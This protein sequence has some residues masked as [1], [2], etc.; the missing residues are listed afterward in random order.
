MARAVPILGYPSRAACVKAL[1]AEGLTA[2]AI[3]ARMTRESGQ[4]IT[5]GQVQSILANQRVARGGEAMRVSVSGPAYSALRKAAVRRGL[6]AHSLA[7]SI[8][9]TV[10]AEDMIDAVLD[11]EVAAAARGRTGAP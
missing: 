9:E 11:D 4:E 6:K 2:R 7:A 1:L 8:I 5:V 10:A 3:A